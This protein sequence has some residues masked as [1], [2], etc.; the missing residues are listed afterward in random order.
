MANISRFYIKNNKVIDHVSEIDK[1][2]DINDFALN[3]VKNPLKQNVVNKFT[4]N[5]IN[6][7]GSNE[8]G[9]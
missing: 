1:K 7:R 3:A 6:R 9:G 8:K 4:G 5:Y 2:K